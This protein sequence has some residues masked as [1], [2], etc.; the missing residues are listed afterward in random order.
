MKRSPFDATTRIPFKVVEGKLVHIYGGG[1]IT[2]L[3]NGAIG[4]IVVKTADL[5]DEGRLKQYNSEK[6]VDFLPKGAKLRARVKT[7]S[8]PEA[9]KKGFLPVSTE[10]DTAYVEIILQQDLQLQLRGTKDARLMPCSCLVPFLFPL[11]RMVFESVLTKPTV[12]SLLTTN[13]IDDRTQE[14]FLMKSSIGSK[15]RFQVGSRSEIFDK[16]QAEY[17]DELSKKAIPPSESVVTDSLASSVPLLLGL[18][19]Q[20][21]LT[22]RP[23]SGEVLNMR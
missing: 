17:E 21:L 7:K 12:S 4:D 5:T 20:T 19:R 13:H 11:T 22:R 18:S 14:M 16:K 9:L 8:I 23:R 2:E 15:L 10:P 1:E 3:R 6:I